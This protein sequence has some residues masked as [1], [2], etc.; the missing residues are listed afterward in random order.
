MIFGIIYGYF[1]IGLMWAWYCLHVFYDVKRLDQK[2]RLLEMASI[3]VNCLLFPFC[4]LLRRMIFVIG[5]EAEEIECDVD[6]EMTFGVGVM[7]E[8][9]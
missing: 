7:V 2:Y 6:E 4:V 5:V 1:V 9:L 8:P 3:I